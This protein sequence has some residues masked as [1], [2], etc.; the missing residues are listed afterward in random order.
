ML[1]IQKNNNRF[2][3]H[4]PNLFDAN[5]DTL[6]LKQL[7]LTGCQ[8]TWA[9][10]ADLPAYEKLDQILVSTDWELKF[11]LAFVQALCRETSDHRAIDK[12]SVILN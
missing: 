11:P 5:I 7:A 6:N 1:S 9:N 8:F 10:Y 3:S 12:I 2:Q 4:W